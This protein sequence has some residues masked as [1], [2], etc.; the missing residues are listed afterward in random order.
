MIGWLVVVLALL[1]GSVAWGQAT[2]PGSYY[3]KADVLD[4]RLGPQDSARSTNRIYRGQRVDVFEVRGGWARVSQFY[5]GAIEGLSGQVARWVKASGL[6]ATEPSKA[7]ASTSTKTRDPRIAKDAI[8]EAGERGLSAKD[9]AFLHKGAL[10]FLNEGKCTHVE[11]ADKSVSKPNTYYV[12][13]GGP[14]LFF[15]PDDLK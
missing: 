11:L 12:N 5:D 2:S 15:T 6:S 1:W 3:V 8:P 9:V 4:E 7:E 10:K 14:N 13:C